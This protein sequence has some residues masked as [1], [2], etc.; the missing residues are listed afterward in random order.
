[1]RSRAEWIR[2]YTGTS[3][4]DVAFALDLATSPGE[5]DAAAWLSLLLFDVAGCNNG[6]T[7]HDREWPPLHKL[8][9]AARIRVHGYPD[10]RRRIAEIADAG[11]VAA[12]AL[13]VERRKAARAER[14]AEIHRLG[15]NAAVPA[16]RRPLRT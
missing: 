10:D 15:F 13:G 11:S 12:A 2:E 16:R 5:V 9:C 3:K 8:V 7:E 6:F 14:D 4:A 1:M